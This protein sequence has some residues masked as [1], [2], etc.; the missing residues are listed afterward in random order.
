MGTGQFL[1]VDGRGGRFLPGRSVPQTLRI[2]RGRSNRASGRPWAADTRWFVNHTD[3][4][5]ITWGPGDSVQ[6]GRYD[7]HIEID[8]AT[9]ALSV[10]QDATRDTFGR[11]SHNFGSR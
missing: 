5:A 6:C 9:V 3:I 8:E 4:P 7:E 2:R 1:R 10:L 11:V